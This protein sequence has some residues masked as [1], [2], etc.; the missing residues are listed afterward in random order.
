[1]RVGL[2][3]ITAITVLLVGMRIWTAAPDTVRMTITE[4]AGNGSAPAVDTTIFDRTVHDA[5]LAQ[6]LQRDVT[7]LA[8]ELPIARIACPQSRDT[9]DTYTLT[10][11][12]SGLFVEQAYT[13]ATGCRTWIEDG[14]LYRLPTSDTI[15]FD[16]HAA[17]GVP[18]PPNK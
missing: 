2:I 9:Y 18:L 1:V 16:L 3:V 6:R 13:I 12:R 15:Y 10:W 5:A 14:V 17:L 11:S 8:I 7:A 4:H